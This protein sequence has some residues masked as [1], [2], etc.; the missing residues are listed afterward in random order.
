[1]SVCRS[2]ITMIIARTYGVVVFDNGPFEA[3]VTQLHERHSLECNRVTPAE[4]GSLS[5]T[6]TTYVLTF[7]VHTE[8][9]R[10]TYVLF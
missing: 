4:S 10:V 8:F 5:S 3:G 6:R 7:I 9:N 1:M 2:D